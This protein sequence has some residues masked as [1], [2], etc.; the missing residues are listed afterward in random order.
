MNEF[1]IEN[2]T[3]IVDCYGNLY[4][5]SSKSIHRGEF[6]RIG[7]TTMR[8]KALIVNTYISYGRYDLLKQVDKA[9][10]KVISPKG[11]CYIT[12]NLSEFCREL[13]LNYSR[14]SK[15]HQMGHRTK[16]GWQ[17]EQLNK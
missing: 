1:P 3:L 16:C 4:D 17:V 5:S 8:T 14:I 6:I 12:L 2:T 15:A 13:G 10:Y 7:Q 11:A 9:V